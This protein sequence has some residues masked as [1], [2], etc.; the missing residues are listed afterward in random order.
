MHAGCVLLLTLTHLGHAC[1]D[2]LSSCDG[3]HVFYFIIMQAN[4]SEWFCLTQA[5]KSSTCQPKIQ[6]PKCPW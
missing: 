4:D 3:M 5:F 1:K 6:P 2:L